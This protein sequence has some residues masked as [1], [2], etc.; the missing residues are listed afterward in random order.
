MQSIEHLERRGRP[1]GRR[2]DEAL[3]FETLARTLEVI[4]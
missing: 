3:L 2:L 4:V 1:A